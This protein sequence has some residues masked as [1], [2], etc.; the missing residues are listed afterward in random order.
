MFEEMLECK[1]YWSGKG[2]NKRYLLL[3]ESKHV[4][5]DRLK[6]LTGVDT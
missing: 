5:G 4:L 1:K 2:A 3:L 6:V